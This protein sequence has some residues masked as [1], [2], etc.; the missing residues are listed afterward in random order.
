MEIIIGLGVLF[1]TFVIYKSIKANKNWK[2]WPTMEE[3]W[4]QYPNCRTNHGTRCYKC[5]SN[6]IRHHGWTK[7]SDNRRIHICNQC[8]TYLYRRHD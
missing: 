1:L 3:Y 2:S 7:N 8:G 5:N 6:Y 4:R